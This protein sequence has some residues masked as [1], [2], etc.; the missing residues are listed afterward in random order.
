MY[1][2]KNIT[3]TVRIPKEVKNDIQRYKIKISK[4][5]RKALEEEIKRRKLEEL[6]EAADRLG[7]L[8]AQ[9]PDEE[10]VKTIKETR[11]LR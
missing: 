8:L 5:V 3:I 4:V 6:K 11:K 10:I 7:E 2:K 1:M 9:I